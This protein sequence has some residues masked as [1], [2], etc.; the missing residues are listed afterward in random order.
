MLEADV[1]LANP[2]L[3]CDDSAETSLAH[4]PERALRRAESTEVCRSGAQPRCTGDRPVIGGR[5]LSRKRK[6]TLN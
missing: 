6:V 1:G 5:P 2:R 4:E 3:I